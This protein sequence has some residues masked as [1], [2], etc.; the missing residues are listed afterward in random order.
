MEDFLV[1]MYEIPEMLDKL[2][3]D[4]AKVAYGRGRNKQA[5][6]RATDLVSH[7]HDK[8]VEAQED[9]EEEMGIAGD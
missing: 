9:L 3:D 2:G 8:L 6:A 5:M 7:S 1:R 4:M